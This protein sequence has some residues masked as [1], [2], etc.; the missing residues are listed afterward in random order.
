MVSSRTASEHASKKVQEKGTA[1]L[2]NA[3]AP[4]FIHEQV[5]LFHQIAD[6]VAEGDRVVNR[7]AFNN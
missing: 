1:A 7:Q 6:S 3:T 2:F 5:I 4:C